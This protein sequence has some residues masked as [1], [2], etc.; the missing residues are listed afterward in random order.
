MRLQNNYSTSYV[1][2]KNRI[3]MIKYELSNDYGYNIDG[4]ENRVTD[5]EIIKKVSCHDSK[6]INNKSLKN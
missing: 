1:G 6:N 5:N 3:N 2:S 4:K